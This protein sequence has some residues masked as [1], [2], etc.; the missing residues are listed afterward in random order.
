MSEPSLWVQSSRDTQRREIGAFFL[1]AMAGG[2]WEISA[3][4]ELLDSG[5]A[6][7][8]ATARA[9]AEA[10][11]RQLLERALAALGPAPMTAPPARHDSANCVGCH[12]SLLFGDGLMCTERERHG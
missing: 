11:V 2:R 6:E 3:F 12:Q 5:E 9:C 1:W 10:A 7:S 8:Q 4:G